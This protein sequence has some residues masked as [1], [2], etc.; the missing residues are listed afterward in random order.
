MIE[1]GY[2]YKIAE[3]N[4][5]GVYVGSTKNFKRRKC[6]HLF[7]CAYRPNVSPYNYIIEKGGFDNF[8]FSVIKEVSN[9]ERQDLLKQEGKYIKEIGTLNK[10]ISGR[11]SKEYNNTIIQCPVCGC[12]SY[13]KNFSRH[14][15]S[16]K[17]KNLL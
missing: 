9:I 14:K 11:T 10:K 13:R 4:G 2:I 7:S 17:H 6:Q 16:N 3:N 1:K 12:D 15:K 5:N 8:T